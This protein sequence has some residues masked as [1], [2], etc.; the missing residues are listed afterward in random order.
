MAVLV[1]VIFVLWWLC[2]GYVDL[3]VWVAV[4][5][6]VVLVVAQSMLAINDGRSDVQ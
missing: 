1:V 6:V 5:M 4:V 3:A 2:V